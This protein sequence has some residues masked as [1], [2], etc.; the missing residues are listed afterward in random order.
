MK[1]DTKEI[2]TAFKIVD[3]VDTQPGLH[4][5]Q[6]VRLEAKKNILQMSLTGL[7][8]SQV[9][10]PIQ[11]PG[12][13]WIWFID[14]RVLQAFLNTAKSKTII[15][16]HQKDALLWK[17]GRQ[18]ITATPM[19][20][21]TGYATWEVGKGASKL[22]LT[23][24][25]RKELSIHAQYAPV[26][27]A[28]D[29]LSAVCLCK[30]YGVL[31]SDSFVIATCLDK[32]QNSNLKLPVQ[33]ASVLAANNGASTALVDKAGT[34][35]QYPQG[36]LYQPLSTNCITSYP[37]KKITEVIASHRDVKPVVKIKA[38]IFFEALTHLKGY[39]FG[40]ATDSHVTCAASPTAG[41]AS[42][43]LDVV[44]SNVQ[45]RIAAE[46]NTD[47]KMIWMIAKLLP[48]VE[49][50]ASLDGDS[51]IACGQKDGCYVFSV[52]SK[53]HRILA[54]AESA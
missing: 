21:I 19:E 6:F 50:I 22:P 26:T 30:N 37:L 29:H 14:R 7:C 25:L 42:L 9:S 35:I 24:E 43:S 28:A 54:I 1:F 33:L 51:I 23:P 2:Q 27:A 12:Q 18:K 49:H 20:P 13:D 47:F 46:F 53:Q 48:W 5:S 40:A 11:E 17:S 38:K 31:A 10:C 8:I 45:T 16:E 4:S 3:Q 15:I 44:Q 32:T 36:Y 41:F 39:I 52:R 34:G